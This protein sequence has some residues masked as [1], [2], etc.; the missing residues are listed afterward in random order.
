[1]RTVETLLREHPFFEGMKA[2]YITSLVGCAS[3]AHFAARKNIFNQDDPADHFY[4]I[5]SGK[6]AIDIESSDRGVITIETIGPGKVLGWSWLFPPYRWH[7]AARAVED[8]K[9]IAMDAR[10]L[11]GK[12]EEDPA[13]GYEMMKRFSAIMLRRMQRARIQLLD[14]FGPGKKA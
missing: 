6:V 8:T 12:F 5:Q 4:I 7:Y 3:N 14:M 2:D 1:M 10:C 11:R 9:A 13:M